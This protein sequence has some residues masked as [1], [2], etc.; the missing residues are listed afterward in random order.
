[1]ERQVALPNFTLYPLVW[2]SVCFAAGITAGKYSG[3]DWKIY[4]IASLIFGCVTA[5][6]LKRRP[7]IIFLSISF[8]SLGAFTFQSREAHPEPN[9]LRSAFENGRIK[10]GDPVEIEGVL[11][12]KPEVAQTGYYL[13]VR[14]G[15]AFY[16]GAEQPVTGTV[17]YFAPW[18]NDETRREYEA[19]DLQYG[20]RVRVAANLQ[21]DESFLNPGV[22]SRTELMDQMET[23]AS[24]VIE[25]PLLV[26]KLGD[27]RVFPPLKWVYDRRQELIDEF[28]AKFSVSTAG[29]MIASLLGNKEFLDRQTAEVFREGGTFHV[30]V[31][32]GMHITFIGALVIFFLRV[33]TKRRVWQFIIA[34]IFLWGYTLAVGAQVPVTRAAIMF[35]ILLLAQV[36]MRQGT[37]LNSLGACGLVL[38]VWRPHDLF[39]ASFQL[40]FMSVGAI[41]ACAF[42]L[43]ENLRAIGGWTPN[44]TMPFPANVP[45]WLKRLCEMLYWRDEVWKIDRKRNVWSANLFKSPYLR[46]LGARGVQ[47]LAA[48]LFEGVLVSLIVQIWLLPLLVVYFNRFSFASILLNLWVGLFMGLESFSA[49]T[50]LFF[51]QIN[52]ALALPLV[53]L[54]E[55]FNWLLLS[56][57]R[58]FVSN[59]WSSV[60]PA[61]YSGPMRFVYF[62]YF[63]PVLILAI[64]AN[65]WNPFSYGRGRTDASG[66]SK[67]AAVVIVVLSLIIIFHPFSAPR[68]DGKLRV[69]FLDVGQGDST[70]VTFPD[71]RTLLIDGGGEASR[72]TVVE[73]EGE[74]D[75]VF[76]PDRVR[77]GE[78]V[79]SAFL[80]QKGY[81]SVDYILATH[82]DLDH[83]QGLADVAKNFRVRGALLAR[84]PAKDTDFVELSTVLQKREVPV[85]GIGRGDVLAF[86]GVKIEV[87][88]PAPDDSPDAVWDNDHS[89]VLR[90]T[91]GEK[92]FLLTGD[93]ESGAERELLHDPSRLTADVVKVAHHGSKTSSTQDF[94]TAAGAKYAIIPVGRT[95]RF[96]HPNKEVVERWANSGAKVMTTGE[97]GTISIVTDGRELKIT[98]YLDDGP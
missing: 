41:V 80:W 63:I 56:V 17:R 34:N 50:A 66:V 15:K 45:K 42:P 92:S 47:G 62:L 25:S 11:L 89:V 37:L 49:V 5:V 65:R 43:I 90:I 81:S 98:T 32:S 33:F 36:V 46:W 73:R 40:T 87:L 28:R 75:E 14:A 35:T 10:T 93:I 77:V 20:S 74:E 8:V 57:P 21:R 96:G 70:L 64:A 76:E 1:M 60:R 91:F 23:G 55:I 67:W 44:S 97:K 53:K 16:K 68:A 31:I 82:A 24:G 13:Q 26:E 9:R 94:V 71:G 79:V 78:K 88:Y 86:E 12:G 27:E 61:L 38:L 51:A 39:T 85:V 83:I 54:T 22:V 69:D 72:K 59:D 48:Y 6:F 58:V 84:N 7:A 18:R 2:L 4:L 29:V 52:D 95:S 30:L 3:I 19:L